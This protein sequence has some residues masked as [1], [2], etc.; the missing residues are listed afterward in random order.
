MKR[1]FNH[2]PLHDEK[3]KVF[4]TEANSLCLGRSR[5]VFG[6][7]LVTDRCQGLA[8]KRLARL[9]IADADDNVVNHAAVGAMIAFS[10]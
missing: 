8:I 1:R 10:K 2:R 6:R 4:P 5:D 7:G 3:L 9:K